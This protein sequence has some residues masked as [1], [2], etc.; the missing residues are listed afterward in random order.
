MIS[1]S[2]KIVEPK[3][4][5][6]YI[7]D[8]VASE[9]EALVKVDCVAICKADLRYYEGNRDRR[10]LGLKY[11]MNLLHEATG[12][13]IADKSKTLEIGERVVLV[14]NIIK[15]PDKCLNCVC[16]IDNLGENYCPKALFASSNT[17]GFSKEIINYP[18]NNLIKIP[19]NLESR[20]AVFTELI[21]VALASYRRIQLQGHEVIGVWGDGILGYIMC[22]VLQELHPNGKV[23]GI[24]KHIEKIEK[25]P[26]DKSYLIN[27]ENIENENIDIVFECVG[28]LG[29]EGAINEA[30]ESINVG[31]TIVL[32]GVSENLVPLNTRKVLEKGIMLVG[33]TRSNTTDFRKAISLFESK[34]FKKNIERLI[35]KEL[36][37]ENIVD[38]YDAF[39]QDLK[40][41]KLGK[42]II[43]F[44][45]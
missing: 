5:D 2:F 45:V 4:F 37:V 44:N 43:Q 14:P 11:P 31:G 10:L 1:K 7:E 41:R 23:I 38:Y 20:I 13:V 40:N 8:I 17:D 39:E 29:A 32:T 9:G 24:G 34:K 18:I 3:R 28:G 42:S 27:D 25:L 33:V 6:L 26:V 19:G 15:E 35:L 12:I 21:S 36:V 22:T 30:I 16:H